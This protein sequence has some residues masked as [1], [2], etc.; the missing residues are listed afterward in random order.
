MQEGL[1]NIILGSDVNIAQEAKK[2]NRSKRGEGAGATMV[3]SKLW[4]GAAVKIMLSEI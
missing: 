1:Q 2:A 3:S 4:G